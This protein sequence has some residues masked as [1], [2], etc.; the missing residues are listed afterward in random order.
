[1]RADRMPSGPPPSSLDR[2]TRW[3]G[4]SQPATGSAQ[5]ASEADSLDT[6]ASEATRATPDALPV[7]AARE[8]RRSRSIAII[9]GSALI[10]AAGLAFPFL[11]ARLPPLIAEESRPGRIRF[12]TQP[13]GA[14]VLVDGQSRGYTPLSMQLMPGKYAVVIRSGSEQRAVPLEVASGVEVTQHYEFLERAP[15]A[16]GK[17]TVVTDPPGARVVI[18]DEPR[19]TSPVT[20]EVSPAPHTI[21]VSNDASTAERTITAEA[22]VESSLVFSLA[23]TPTISAGWLAVTAP[24]DVQ[25][26]EQNE[27]L[28]TSAASKFMVS[29]G[30][31]DVEFVNA[32]LGYREPRRLEVS[33]G[34]TTALRLDAKATLSVNARPWAE[35]TIDGTAAGQTPI[36]GISVSLGPHQIVFRHPQFGERRES[37][38]VNAKGPNRV[39]VDMTK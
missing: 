37:V 34:K 38:V 2:L 30:R 22:G 28:G 20:V 18:D 21:V 9:A 19:G 6:F 8:P 31:H 1:M 15:L 17:L 26:L 4:R 3:I 27:L 13:L 33:A 25:V 10:V 29:A 16:L 11:Q 14:E 36:S 39:G 35:V 7:V 5:G 24:F 32:A 12:E 23:K